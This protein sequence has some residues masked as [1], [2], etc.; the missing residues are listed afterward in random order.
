MTP[1]S[2]ID[3]I[4]PRGDD[5]LCEESLGCANIHLSDML[6]DP[7][8]AASFG[9]GQILLCT[10]RHYPCSDIIK[11]IAPLFCILSIGRFLAIWQ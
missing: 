5:I 7:H 1:R 9:R 11:N 6:G 3:P 4:G 10:G 2:Y 8:V